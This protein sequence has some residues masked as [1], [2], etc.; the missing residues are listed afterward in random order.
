MND[1]F[2]HFT[3][4]SNDPTTVSTEVQMDGQ[5]LKGVTRVVFEASVREANKITLTFIAGSLN[6]Q[7]EAVAETVD[8]D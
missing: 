4:T 3:I 1:R 5:P 8:E 6:A 2:H 7:V